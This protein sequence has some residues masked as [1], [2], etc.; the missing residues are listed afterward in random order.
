MKIIKSKKLLYLIIASVLGFAAILTINLMTNREEL[1]FLYTIPGFALAPYLIS[2]PHIFPHTL[3]AWIVFFSISGYYLAV[4]L[5]IS[6]LYEWS[7]ALILC[8]LWYPMTLRLR[9]PSRLYAIYGFIW[10][11]VFFSTTNFIFSP[12]IVW[13]V[14]PICAAAFWPLTAYFLSKKKNIYK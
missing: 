10:S 13:A 1:W 14:Y 7:V 2:K 9:Y 12:T 6:P 11:I 8:L 5:T 3:I 4:N